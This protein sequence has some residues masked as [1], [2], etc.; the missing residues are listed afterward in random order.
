[1]TSTSESAAT[2]VDAISSSGESST[3]TDIEGHES[4]YPSDSY[5]E[6]GSDSEYS[7]CFA[8]STTSDDGLLDWQAI[9]RQAL[10][11]GYY[12]QLFLARLRPA[13]VVPII[14]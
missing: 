5:S 8:S 4:D 1:M 12:T 2:D 9:R 11:L 13:D 3:A 7:K 6:G 10:Q 14:N